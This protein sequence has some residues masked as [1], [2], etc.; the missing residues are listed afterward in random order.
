VSWEE[1][2]YKGMTLLE[3]GEFEEAIAQFERAMAEGGGTAERA[4]LTDLC[5][6]TWQRKQRIQG[7]NGQAHEVDEM[8]L[9]SKASAVLRRRLK[10]K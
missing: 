6:S 7:L 5:F 4:V 1:A 10:E 3:R 9:A 8:Q 2:F